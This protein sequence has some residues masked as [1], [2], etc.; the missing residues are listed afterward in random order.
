M[1]K[2]IRK[3]REIAQ[4]ANQAAHLQDV[5][6]LNAHF[7][8]MVPTYLTLLLWSMISTISVNGPVMPLY[9]ESL[10]ISVV[11]WGVLAASWALGMFVSEWLW[12]SLCDRKDRRMLMILSLLGSSL[13]FASFTVH[14]LIPIFILLEFLTGVMGVAM[15]PVTR[16]YISNESPEASMGFYMSM[17]W[18]SFALGR[19]FGPIL[20]AYLAQTWS[21]E[22]SFWISSLLCI[23]LTVFI[24]A[25]F[26]KQVSPRQVHSVNILGGVK[27][28]L[29]LKSARSILIATI[30]AFMAR[31][32]L[33]TFLPLYASEQIKM[34]TIQVGEL[35]SAVFAA[36]LLALP[37]VGWCAD[38]FGR[39]RTAGLGLLAS[40]CL[41]LL[42]F[43]AGTPSQFL[44]VSIAIGL[45]LSATS[46]LL[47][48]IPDVTPRA[49][50]GTAIGIYGSFEDLGVGAGPLIFGFVWTIFAPVYIFGATSITLLLAAILMY[51]V[52]EKEVHYLTRSEST[53]K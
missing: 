23:A 27:S 21:F 43:I 11:E 51:T 50:H 17:W 42:Y 18:A 52:N 9:V 39:R 24:L 35:S 25:S 13:V 48:M 37:I 15:G 2:K 14:S 34:S 40:S 33:S 3:R 49:M 36:Q 41:F 47:A 19:V 31:A 53:T 4:F 46:L 20:G 32:L 6:S 7:R 8:V 1:I 16:S 22:F 45:G 29:S 30:F 28:V 10:G 12:G 44:F 26:P 38:R 5:D